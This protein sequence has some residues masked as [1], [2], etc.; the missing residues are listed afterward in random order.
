LTHTLTHHR[1]FYEVEADGARKNQ[2]IDGLKER[3]SKMRREFEATKAKVEA[4]EKEKALEAA[5]IETEKAQRR[6][7]VLPKSP[8]KRRISSAEPNGRLGVV[9][10]DTVPM[11]REQVHCSLLQ[12]TT[13]AT[14]T[15]VAASVT[16][17]TRC[18]PLAAAIIALHVLHRRH[19]LVEVPQ[20]SSTRAHPSATLHSHTPL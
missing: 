9:A 7:R 15:A 17:T 2:E 14:A 18:R 12:P 20:L 3:L 8:N 11:N 16:T 1:I 4:A 13:I 6:R 19:R 5:M 10:V